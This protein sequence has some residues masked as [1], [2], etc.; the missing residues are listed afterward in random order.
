MQYTYGL[1][2][3]PYCKTD[4]GIFG[5]CVRMKDCVSFHISIFVAEFEN[6]ATLPRDWGWSIQFTL[7]KLALIN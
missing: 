7:K 6:V 1:F 2:Y 5:T 3:A 4:L